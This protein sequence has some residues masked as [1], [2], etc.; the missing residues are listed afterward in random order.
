MKMRNLLGSVMIGGSLLA[1]TAQPAQA[2][3][4]SSGKIT[5]ILITGSQH[6]IVQFD[7]PLQSRASCTTNSIAMAFDASTAK[8][9]ALLSAANAALLGNLTVNLVGTQFGST[10]TCTNVLHPG[11]STA[12][13]YET[14]YYLSMTTS[15]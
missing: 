8:G 13:A 10:A 14:L 4:L 15:F 11:S 5:S 7:N 9:K 6:V 2:G 1:F 3:S 12:V